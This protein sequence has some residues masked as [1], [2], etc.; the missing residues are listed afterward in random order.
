MLYC[1]VHPPGY[2][3]PGYTLPVHH[4][5]GMVNIPVDVYVYGNGPL[6]SDVDGISGTGSWTK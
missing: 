5:P 4:P 3:P 1:R 2:T 6:G